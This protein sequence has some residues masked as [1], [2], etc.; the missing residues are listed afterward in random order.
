[1]PGV[2]LTAKERILIH[3]ADYAKYADVVEVTPE[4]GQEGIAH[5]AGIYVQHVRQFIDP[6]L[7]EGL[8]RERTAHVKGHR[9]RLKVYDLTDSGRLS[10]SRLREQVRGE[11]I[12]VRD[13]TGLRETTAT[14]RSSGPPPRQEP[15]R[16]S[17]KRPVSRSSSAA[18]LSSTPSRGRTERRA[19]S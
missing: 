13:A 2:R 15:W 17:R 11:R 9:R 18:N 12:R 6:L 4:M 1:M 16:A 3:L 5:A 7:K 19:S 14:W 8:V 10:A